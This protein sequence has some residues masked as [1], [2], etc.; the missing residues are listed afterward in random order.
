MPTPTRFIHTADW[1][2]G[3]R[4]HFIPGDSGA[5]VRDAR[6]GTVR[7]IGEVAREARAEF[8]LVAGDVFEHHGL[9]PETLR[10]AFDMMAEIPVPV[11]LLPGNHDPLTPD[12]LYRTERW[13]RE[14]P[15]NVHVL[16]TQEP[17]VVREGVTLFGCP[18]LERHTLSDTTDH[19]IPSFGPPD[20]VR[21][22]VAHGGI[23]EFLERLVGEGESINNA[24]AVDRAETARLDYLA[25]G[26]WHGTLK[27]DDHTWYSG[28]PEATRFKEKDPGSVLVV[29]IDGPGAVP[30]VT[31]RSV[32]GM[33]WKKETF[34]VEL[35]TDLVALERF[36]DAIPRK[37]TTLLELTLVGTLEASLRARLDD[38]VLAKAHDRLRFLR[39]RD[40]RLYTILSADDL[41]SLPAEGWVGSAVKGLQSEREGASE[42][43]RARALRLLYR[44]HKEVS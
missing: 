11:Y 44:L 18:L 23:R 27:I 4:A 35:E 25:L 34:T 24:I 6:F 15:S 29:E 26:D 1:Q 37:D 28:T 30:T 8:V 16:A 43:E 5:V 36:L 19:L 41:A 38:Q 10:K 20:H 39:V 2:L 42:Q 33:E 7:R 13:R 32:R 21:I 3:L 9:K 17:I 40:E 22:G 31:P 14:A 12:A